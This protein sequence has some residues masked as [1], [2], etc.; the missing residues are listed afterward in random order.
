MS[1]GF[2]ATS[3]NRESRREPL[4]EWHVWNLLT[5]G[6]KSYCWWFSVFWAL[7]HFSAFL[8]FDFPRATMIATMLRTYS[9]NDAL[10]QKV[11]HPKKRRN[12]RLMKLITCFTQFGDLSFSSFWDALLVL[13]VQTTPI[14]WLDIAGK[15][16]CSYISGRQTFIKDSLS[17]LWDL[18]IS[19]YLLDSI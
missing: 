11:K 15:R 16:W 13:H 3:S 17:I 19:L 10:R 5:A 2:V 9:P 1:P 14:L 18:S 4:S 7:L 12:R 8:I 6:H